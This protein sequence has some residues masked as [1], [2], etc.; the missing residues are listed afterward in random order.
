MGK[1]TGNIIAL[2]ISIGY[3]VLTILT[4]KGVI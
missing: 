1:A 3:L 2:I 4:L